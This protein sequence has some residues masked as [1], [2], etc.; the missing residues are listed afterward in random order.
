MTSRGPHQVVAIALAVLLGTSACTS[1]TFASP[2]VSEATAKSSAPPSDDPA[3]I[4]VEITPEER[5]TCDD[6]EMVERLAAANASP[7]EDSTNS[8]LVPPQEI[9]EVSG[10]WAKAVAQKETW[11]ELSPS[12]RLF[13]LC[14]LELSRS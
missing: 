2:D 14:L 1:Q 4:T 3:F 10:S 13:N 8:I 9:L 11:D 12:D 6:P 7:V 5:Q